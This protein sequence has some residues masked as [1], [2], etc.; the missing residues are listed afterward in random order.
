MSATRAARTAL[1][2]VGA[3][4]LA[5]TAAAQSLQNLRGGEDP[6][7]ITA[8]E[9]IE[10]RRDEQVYIARGDA[11]ARRGDVTVY[12]ETLTAHY[13]ELDDGTKDIYRID[14]VNDVRIESP[15]ETVYGDRGVYDVDNAVLVLTG[16]DLRLETEQDVIT[17]R[18]SLEYWEQRRLAVAR[19]DAVVLREDKRVRADVVT[20]HFAAES[21]GQQTIRRVDAYDDVEIATRKE[22][23][24]GDKATYLVQDRLATVTGGVKITRDGNQLNGG[25][26]EVNLDTGV[27]RLLAGPPGETGHRRVQGLLLPGTKPTPSDLPIGGGSREGNGTSGGGKPAGEQGPS[28]DG[29]SAEESP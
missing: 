23:I 24:R 11:V 1:F 9:G 3:L 5:A 29:D 10:W 12:A 18:D 26:A 17:A 21:D 25:Y 8:S 19:G 6:L 16:D 2:A 22:V 27:S 14:A 28:E 15:S 20:A 7:E 4:A 13:R